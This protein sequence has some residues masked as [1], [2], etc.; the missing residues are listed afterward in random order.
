MIQITI[1][2]FGLLVLIV[3]L[4]W[5]STGTKTKPEPLAMEMSIP[6]LP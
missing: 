3:A 2:A 5:W 1:S 6:E 4:I